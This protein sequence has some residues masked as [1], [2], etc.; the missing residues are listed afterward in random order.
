MPSGTE[1]IDCGRC[2]SPS[3]IPSTVPATMLMSAA[4]RTLRVSKTRRITNVMAAR[5][6]AGCVRSPKESATFCEFA[7]SS[8]AFRMPITA[9]NMPT[10]AL[11]E[12]LI[13]RG[14]TSMM[15]SRTPS[16]V[17]R[18]NK[19]PL[20]NTIAL[21]IPIDTCW[22]CTNVIEKI[23]TLPMPGANTKGRLVYSPIATVVRN[24]IRTNAVST[25]PC[26][27]PVSAIMRG[28]TAST[29]PIV[30]KIVSPAIT[31]VPISV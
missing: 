5:T 28:T 3:G 27:R 9:R 19:T 31:S 2:V 6:T 4:P 13:P 20:R 10:P 25:A 17:T 21:A 1:K 7:A 30:A 8:L 24:I 23:A 18:M 22:S 26:G 12:I 16:S 29:Y 15:A 11:I 14:M